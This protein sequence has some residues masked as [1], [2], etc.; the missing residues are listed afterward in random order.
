MLAHVV[1]FRPRADLTETEQNDL[2]ASLAKA[3]EE[4]PSIRRARIGRRVTHGRPY[5]QLM[6]ADYSYLA[7]LEFDDVAGLQAYLNHPAHEQLATR[8][9]AAFEEA[10]MYDYALEEGADAR[11]QSANFFTPSS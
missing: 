10:L 4:I 7:L 1:L 9:F 2:V 6:R 8:F 3:L 11:S 5:E